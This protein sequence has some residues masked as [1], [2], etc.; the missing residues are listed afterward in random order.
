M[1]AEKSFAKW[2]VPQC[3]DNPKKKKK[4]PAGTGGQVQ[5][6][7]N[8]KKKKK[9]K[10]FQYP[11]TSERYVHSH[12]SLISGL[13]AWLVLT[14][15]SGGHCCHITGAGDARAEPGADK[16]P[17]GRLQTPV[18]SEQIESWEKEEE[19]EGFLKANMTEYLNIDTAARM[20]R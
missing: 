9:W 4:N 17:V 2:T 12:P 18:Q 1:A 16:V 11:I 15:A 13:G 7:K 8:V 6:M 14:S 20:H 10:R 5:R 19:K 3:F